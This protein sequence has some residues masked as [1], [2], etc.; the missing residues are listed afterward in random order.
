MKVFAI[1]D[2]ED[3]THKNLAYLLYYERQKQFYIELPDDA[4]EWETPLLLSSFVKRGEYTINAYWSKRWV[5]QRIVPMDR[6][7]LGQ[8]LKVN[9]LEE[10]D[11]YELLVLGEGRCAQDNY[12]LV[13][14]CK[15]EVTEKFWK[16]YQ[17]KVEDVV[18]LAD[19]RLLVFFRDGNVRKCNMRLML[20]G[21]TRFYV[22]L[23]NERLFRQVKVQTGGYGICW[24]EDLCVSDER[25]YSGGKNVPLSLADFKCFISERIVNTAEAA[26]ILECSRQ[27]IEDLVRR[28]KVHPV[29]VEAKSK[30]FLKSEIQQRLWK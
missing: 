12:Y 24:G 3:K 13:P 16:R 11:E 27:N 8:I 17:R 30:L 1:R 7:N 10:Y 28:G 18:P 22:I 9:G 20:A 4:D 19:A 6:Q 14:L 29:K 5:Q 25:L 21:N 15:N 23:N 2:E 26:D